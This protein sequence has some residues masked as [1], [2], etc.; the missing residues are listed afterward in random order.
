MLPVPLTRCPRAQAEHIF[1]FTGVRVV[2]LNEIAS[3]A[4]LKTPIQ[5][6][7]V[8]EE[9]PDQTTVTCCRS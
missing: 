6:C 5:S 7:A 9:T 8:G 2:Q 4:G 3:V 1:N